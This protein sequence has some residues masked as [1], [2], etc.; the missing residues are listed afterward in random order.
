MS[1]ELWIYGAAAGLAGWAVWRF[2][3]QYRKFLEDGWN[4]G[5]ATRSRI[6]RHLAISER[7]TGS[8]SS[9]PPAVGP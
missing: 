2:A 6:E 9:T 1:A 3:T 4:G 5:K 8:D 7:R